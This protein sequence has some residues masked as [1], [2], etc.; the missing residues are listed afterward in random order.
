MKERVITAIG[1]IGAFTIA[2]FLGDRA[3]FLLLFAF[4][5]VGSYEIYNLKKDHLK[6]IVLVVIVIA[7]LIGGIIKWTSVP[8][9]G[10]LLIMLLFSMTVTFEW[11]KFEDVTYI[12]ILVMML[13]LT[14]QAITRVLELDRLVFGFILFA[15]YA[16]DTFAYFGGRFFGKH[17][18]IERISP[19]KT[20]E[21]AVIGYVVSAALSL[22]FGLLW[23]TP[24][25]SKEIIIAASLLIPVMGQFGDL[26]FSLIKRHFDIKDFGYIFPGHGGVLDR[27]DSVIF[28]FF[29]FNVLLTFL[30]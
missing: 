21:G 13:I 3:L 8:T 7:T 17:K 23:I 29:T 10:M 12:Y 15:T 16:T 22:T 14:L 26:A 18:L 2:L 24:Y 28:A 19:K 20:V 30:V 4:V 11:F 5:L 1:L 27:I 25:V 6:P 9:F